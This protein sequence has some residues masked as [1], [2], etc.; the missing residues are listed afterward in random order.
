MSPLGLKAS[1][2]GWDK[3][4]AFSAAGKLC[5]CGRAKFTCLFRCTADTDA[6]PGV[7]H[8]RRLSAMRPRTVLLPR[9]PEPSNRTSLNDS[10]LLTT[11]RPSGATAMLKSTVPRPLTR[12]VMVGVAAAASMTNRS[13]SGSVNFTRED[14]SLRASSRHAVPSLRTM[15]PVEGAC[16]PSVLVDKPAFGVLSASRCST[17]LRLPDM[18]TAAYTLRPSLLTARARG[19][20]AGRAS[21]VT[22]LPFKDS[23]S[24][25][26]SNTHT[27]ARPVAGVV[28]EDDV[29]PGRF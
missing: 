20:S 14:Q 18:N 23:S 26:A 24:C 29:K 27:S 3:L 19:T 1:A 8:V 9:R 15:S 25:D 2:V 22:G 17:V 7:T 13:S 21:V 5:P 12:C 6:E 4:R 10:V 28:R 11:R 16:T